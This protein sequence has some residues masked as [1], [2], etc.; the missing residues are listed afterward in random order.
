[1]G[2]F[3]SVLV[4]C[5]NCHCSN[6][7]Q[8]KPGDMNSYHFPKDI[9]EMPV[10]YLQSINDMTWKC[11]HCYTNFKTKMDLEIKISNPVI[12]EI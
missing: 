2:V 3:N 6:D 11:Y 1:M 12:E 10:S 9:N 7:E 5:P 8:F 4:D